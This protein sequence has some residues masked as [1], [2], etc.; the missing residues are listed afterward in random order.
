MPG[1]SNG[2]RIDVVTTSYGQLS[3]TVMEA[4]CRFYR[5][6]LCLCGAAL[7]IFFSSIIIERAKTRRRKFHD[8]QVFT[9]A[10]C[11]WPTTVADMLRIEAQ[12]L[13]ASDA[14]AH[15]SIDGA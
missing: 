2:V 7:E 11:S 4:T 8:F 13:K 1:R 5:R 14:A 6:F 15:R 12:D 9:S 3:V 10:I